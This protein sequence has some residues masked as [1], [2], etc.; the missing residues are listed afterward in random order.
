MKT[1]VVLGIVLFPALFFAQ[2]LDT[3]WTRSYGG[4]SVDVFESAAPC[5]DGGFMLAGWTRSFGAGESDGWLVR[6]NDDGDTLWTRT[7]GGTN[8]DY[9]QDVAERPNGGFIAGGASYMPGS[10]QGTYF[11]AV[12]AG[13]NGNQVWARNYGGQYGDWCV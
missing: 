10:N 3:L 1:S 12:R 11:W 7:Y 13:S 2:Q 8:W 4:D 6:I 9:F 5:A